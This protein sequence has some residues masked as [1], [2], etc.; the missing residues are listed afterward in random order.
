VVDCAVFGVPDARDGEHLKAVVEGRPGVLV[1]E[2]AAHVRSRLADYKV[3]REWELV[4]Q[5]PRD[6]SGK[7]LKRLL[8][9]EAQRAPG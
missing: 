8:R 6:P 5:L 3:P 4:D 9:Q 2:L 7:V 1:D